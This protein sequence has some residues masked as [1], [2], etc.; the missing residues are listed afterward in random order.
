[1]IM[2]RFRTVQTRL[3]SPE[4]G[5]YITYGMIAEQTCGTDWN[6]V[7]VIRDISCDKFFVDQ[8]AEK[9]TWGQLDPI[10]MMDVVYDSIP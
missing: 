1:M 8:L 6:E 7:R 9:C 4:I 10:H 3:F 2:F 5:S